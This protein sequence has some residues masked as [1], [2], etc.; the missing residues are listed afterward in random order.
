MKKK[1]AEIEYTGIVREGDEDIPTR[2]AQDA[3]TKTIL[4]TPAYFIDQQ[5]D[6]FRNKNVKVTI[7]ISIE[8]I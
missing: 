8:E 6:D 4:H 5:I 7:S 1:T 3:V 2:I